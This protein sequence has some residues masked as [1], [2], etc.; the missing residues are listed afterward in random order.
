MTQVF[1]GLDIG[2][3]STKAVLVDATG[4]IHATAR[5]EH[6][7]TLPRPGWAEFDAAGTG[8]DEVT[9]LCR[10]LVTG[11][12]DLTVAGITVSA[13]GPCLIVTGDDLVPLRPTILYGVDTRATAEIAELTTEFGAD[14]ILHSAGKHLSSQS[15]GPKLRWIANHEPEV[16]RRA[17]RWFSL[18]S[19]IAA[20]LSGA[21]VM[22]HVNASQTDPLYDVTTRDWVPDRV[23]AVAEH[24]TPP[25]LV[26]PGDV[27]GTVT[28]DAAAAT[29]L[30]AGIPVCAGTIDAWVEA[31]SVGVR[32]PGDLMVMY[33]STL[34]LV[35]VIDQPV[36]HDTLWTTAGVETG[37][38]TLA[39][40]MATSGSLTG[41]LQRLCGE[42][43][44][45]QL[46]AEAAQSPP[47]AH[48]L[49]LLPH[50]AGERTPLLD[51][52]AR[53]LITGLTLSHTRGDVYRAGYEGIGYGMRQIMELLTGTGETTERM[54]AVGGGTLAPLWLQIVSD[55][56]GREQLVPRV[57]IGAS[58]GDAHL[59]AVGAGAVDNA[60]DWTRVASTVRPDPRWADR[61]GELYELYRTT[62]PLMR[63]HMHAL[64]RIGR[65]TAPD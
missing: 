36:I 45:E 15:T 64:A 37:S 50:F 34:F 57:T 25:E 52:D 17:T 8:W 12:P 26:W 4:T 22:D 6:P 41:W 2:T 11:N 55:I 30:P 58:Y 27:I 54:I 38:L 20:K 47:G 29:A 63:D 24:L 51:P 28:A 33:G 53:G 48:G 5:R 62:Y 40:G 16:W 42:T 59:A 32:G 13:M 14:T 61:Y 35:Q 31:H 39:A 21:Y 46:K 18:N 7:M 56:T 19:W 10:E 49:L 23:R 43:D 60:T 65:E 9:G 44:F 1:L 3:A